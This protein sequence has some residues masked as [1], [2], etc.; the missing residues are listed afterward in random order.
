MWHSPRQEGFVAVT[1]KLWRMPAR[2][3]FSEKLLE[4]KKN[5]R[6]SFNLV[7]FFS[8][9]LKHYFAFYVFLCME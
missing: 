6:F 1:E 4:Y 2:K 8:A 7:L 5:T 9:Y 3:L